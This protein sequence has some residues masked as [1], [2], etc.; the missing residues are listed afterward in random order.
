M[1]A[2]ATE[3]SVD[4]KMNPATRKTAKVVE[5]SGFNISQR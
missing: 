5:P 2:A 4:A 1:N 3:A